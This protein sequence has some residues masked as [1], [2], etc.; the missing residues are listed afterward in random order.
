MPSA[1]QTPYL[2]FVAELMRAFPT[3]PMILLE[4]RHVS[5]CLHTYCHSTDAMASAAAAI[6]ARHGWK[7]AAFM[8]HSYGTFVL[9]RIAQLHRPLVQS[10]VRA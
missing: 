9:S 4:A 8:G 10:M 3:R 6:L 5:V 1:A 7:Q 2:H